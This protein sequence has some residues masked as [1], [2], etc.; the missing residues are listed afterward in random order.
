MTIGFLGIGRVVAA[1]FS[2]GHHRGVRANELEPLLASLL[3]HSTAVQIAA[4][5]RCH[6]YSAMLRTTQPSA[7]VTGPKVAAV[8]ARLS[9]EERHALM[10]GVAKLPDQLMAE[11]LSEYYRGSSGKCC[12]ACRAEKGTHAMPS[13]PERCLASLSTG[14]PRSPR[15]A[16]P[17]SCASTRSCGASFRCARALARVL[18]QTRPTW[19]SARAA[20]TAFV[21][22]ARRTRSLERAFARRRTLESRTPRRPGERSISA[23]SGRKGF[24]DFRCCVHI[25]GLVGLIATRDASRDTRDCE[26]CTARIQNH[27]RPA[28]QSSRGCGG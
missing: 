16:R 22:S 28:W 15:A 10:S 6:A 3:A 8:F 18:V 25:T 23:G 7:C 5:R 4:S 21:T 24:L 19:S 13:G 12:D 11:S 9:W 20:S 14:D 2:G 27:L 26:R 1:C 17:S